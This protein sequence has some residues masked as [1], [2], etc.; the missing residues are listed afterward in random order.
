[1]PIK[2]LQDDR[3]QRFPMIGKLRKGA[4]K[5]DGKMGKDLDHFRFTTEDPAAAAT[6]AS[7]YG[8]TP[9]QVNVLLPYATAA[10]NLEAWL[11]QYTASALQ[12]RCDG[13]TQVFY[14]DAAG[15]GITTP[16]PCPLAQG[17]KCNCKPVGR[18]AVIVPELARLAWVMVETHSQYD[19]IQLTENLEAAQALRGD[20]RGIPFI[21]S[22]RL[23]EIST[24]DG[25]GGRARRAKWLLFLEPDPRWVQRQLLAVQAAAL[26]QFGE[27]PAIA[28]PTMRQIAGPIDGPVIDGETDED[29]D[30]DY[31]EEPTPPPAV[32]PPTTPNGKPLVS[33]QTLAELNQVGAALYGDEW[34]A[35]SVKMAEWVSK[36]AETT[37]DNLTQGEAAGL[38]NGLRERLAKK[39]LTPATQP[40]PDPTLWQHEAA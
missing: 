23:R 16:R 36:G 10:E 5:V 28:A 17:G 13:E 32:K 1:M 6:F 4:A 35:T 25:K 27:M 29:D 33:A 22:R 39:P 7:N 12:V 21:L 2:K 31:E 20:L 37:L 11:E 14:R 40:D 30:A 8:A 38:L 19:I 18:L 15:N 24:P 3:P 9:Q 26:P 34:A